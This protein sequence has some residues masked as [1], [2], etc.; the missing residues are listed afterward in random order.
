MAIFCSLIPKKHT[1]FLTLKDFHLQK[2][3]Q[4]FYA[5]LRLQKL[6][7]NKTKIWLRKVESTGNMQVFWCSLTLKTIC[8]K[9]NNQLF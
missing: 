1:Y 6:F 8:K 5:N 4:P 9:L 7:K 2:L 3:F